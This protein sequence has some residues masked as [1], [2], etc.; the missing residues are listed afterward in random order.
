MRQA[1]AYAALQIFFRFCTRRPFLDRNP[2]E[3]MERP[4]RKGSRDRILTAGELTTVWNASEGMFGEIIRL[5]ILLGQRRS[6]IAQI[7][8]DWLDGDLLTFPADV[9]KNKRR[10][11]FPIGPMA[12]V[13]IN[14]QPRRNDAPNIFPARKT[15][16][17]KSI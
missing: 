15:W 2:M 11:S 13:I 14:E 3:R 5:C 8:W 17:Q 12:Q 10:H 7:R 4:T 1:K 6:E 16:R 9:T